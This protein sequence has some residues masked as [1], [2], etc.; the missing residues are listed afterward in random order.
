MKCLKSIC[1]LYVGFCLIGQISHDTRRISH[2][3]WSRVN[4]AFCLLIIQCAD[5]IIL[6][7]VKFQVCQSKLWN[8][9]YYELLESNV[10]YG[11]VSSAARVFYQR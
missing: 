5:V 10:V 3:A 7:L 2:A 8:K 6:F 9:V 11:G 4:S 1:K